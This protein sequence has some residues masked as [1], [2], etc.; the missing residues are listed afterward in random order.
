M[1]FVQSYRC[2]ILSF[3]FLLPATRKGSL[4]FK[5]IF[6]DPVNCSLWIPHWPLMHVKCGWWGKPCCRGHCLALK[7]LITAVT[8]TQV[9]VCV[10]SS[11]LRQG[12]GLMTS[13]TPPFRRQRLHLLACPPCEYL[14]VCDRGGQMASRLLHF[15]SS[16]FFSAL[17]CFAV[18]ARRIDSL[19]KQQWIAHTLLPLQPISNGSHCWDSLSGSWWS[20]CSW[21]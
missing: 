18:L 10:C 17:C 21:T 7:W 16:L 19:S 13:L 11:R 1:E 5:R 4:D 8:Q 15:V 3:K 14:C 20:L 9:G 6:C 12:S 2:I